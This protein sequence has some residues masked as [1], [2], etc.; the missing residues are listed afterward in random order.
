MKTKIKRYTKEVL[1]FIVTITIAANIL[2]LYKSQNLNKQ[3]LA[4]EY[5]FKKDKPILI[6]FWA[7]WCPTCKVEASNIEKISKDFEV[8]TIAVNSGSNKE[9]KEYMDKNGYTF[10]FINDADSKVAKEFNI[11]AYPTTLI[12]DKDK[13]LVFSEVGYT[14]TIGLY[15][16][17]WWAGI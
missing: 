15:I 9:I 6:H 3:P 7:T 16:R 4:L 11:Q 1:L 13:N 14:S 12:Y 8:L 17:L 5:Q 2:S 10:R